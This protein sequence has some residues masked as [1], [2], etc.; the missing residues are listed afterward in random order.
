MQWLKCV[1]PIEE[2]IP[3]AHAL[4][5]MTE[6]KKKKENAFWTDVKVLLIPSEVCCDNGLSRATQI[7]LGVI[8][9][10]LAGSMYATATDYPENRNIII[11]CGGSYW[12][13]SGVLQFISSYIEGNIIFE[14]KPDSSGEII[15]ILSA[16]SRKR[17]DYEL[18][19]KVMKKNGD[20]FMTKGTHQFGNLFTEKGK[21]VASTFNAW[22]SRLLAEA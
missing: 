2:T 15:R 3:R 9:C 20:V 1:P 19:V 12:I 18:E 8:A 21:L 13:L 6:T 5:Y 7:I 16:A 10:V 11:L 17:E 22:L 14:S 4:Q